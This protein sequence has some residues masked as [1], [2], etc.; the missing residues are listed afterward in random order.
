MHW[1]HRKRL[2][3]QGRRS[4]RSTVLV[5]DDE[6]VR[7]ATLINRLVDLPN[8]TECQE[9]ELFE[10]VTSECLELISLCFP[11]PFF[12]LLRLRA[13]GLDQEVREAL[14]TNL[15]KVCTSQL[16]VPFLDEQD[17]RRI[18]R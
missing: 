9:Q 12:D 14:G 4:E 1:R 6:L 16:K 2:S 3:W 5:H 13:C 17:K 18:V 10:N 8:W 7:M 11:P 15:V